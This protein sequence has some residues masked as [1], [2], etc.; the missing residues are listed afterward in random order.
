MQNISGEAANA[1]TKI[2]GTMVRSHRC[3]QRLMAKRQPEWIGNK[4][5]ELVVY[6]W[7]GLREKCLKL[8][9]LGKRDVG[10]SRL[11]FGGGLRQ[12]EVQGCVGFSGCAGLSRAGK[13]GV[14]MYFV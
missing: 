1:V 9:E 4:Q 10:E 12:F 13:L 7:N 6:H 11:A 14:C 5:F 2:M 3:S 8:K